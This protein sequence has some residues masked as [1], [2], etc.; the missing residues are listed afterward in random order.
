MS[1][2]LTKQILKVREELEFMKMTSAKTRLY[3]KLEMVTKKGTK[4]ALDREYERAF[5][6][7]RSANKPHVYTDAIRAL[8][9]EEN[10]AVVSTYVANIEGQACRAIHLMG[11][12]DRQALIQQ[13]MYLDLLDMGET[14]INHM[15]QESDLCQ[16]HYGKLQA[17][18]RQN[19]AKLKS[20][21]STKITKQVMVMEKLRA[22]LT[23]K[24][25]QSLLPGDDN[26]YVDATLATKVPMMTMFERATSIGN[27]W[28]K[29]GQTRIK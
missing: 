1:P 24:I 29:F 27:V 13:E 19:L 23:L 15:K 3:H 25:E 28:Q 5:E 17:K 18:K 4:A 21:Y 16:K 10:N 2:S 9:G 12:V 20:T 22:L 26:D 7:F 14:L 11:V 6:E 8:A